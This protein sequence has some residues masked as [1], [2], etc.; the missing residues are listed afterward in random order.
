MPIFMKLTF[1]MRGEPID[2]KN[3]QIVYKKFLNGTEKEGKGKW[4]CECRA[5]RQV[6]GGCVT[7]T[8]PGDRHSRERNSSD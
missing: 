5:G 8:Q 4:G 1:L 2:I 3:K 6:A 7:S